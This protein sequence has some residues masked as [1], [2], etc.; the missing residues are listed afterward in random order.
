MLLSTLSEKGARDWL[1]KQQKAELVDRLTAMIHDKLPD[2]RNIRHE[3]FLIISLALVYKYVQPLSARWDELIEKALAIPNIADRVVAIGYVAV[4]LPGKQAGRRKELLTKAENLLEKLPSE[5]DR[6]QRYKWLARL[7][8]KD[9]PLF[10]R[11]FIGAVLRCSFALRDEELAAEGQREAIE[12]AHRID[13]D[14]ADQLA[15]SLDDDPARRRA[16]REIRGQLELLKTK[17]ALAE[18]EPLNLGDA[19]IRGRIPRAAWMNLAALNSKRLEPQRLEQFCDYLEY[20]ASV[21]L[22]VS[23]PVFAWTIESAARRYATTEQAREICVPV[24][25]AALMAS[26]FVQRMMVQIDD[27]IGAR[28]MTASDGGTDAI[29]IGDGEQEFARGLIADWIR[30]HVSDYIKICDPYFVPESLWVLKIVKREKPTARVSILLGRKHLDSATAG[31]V[32]PFQSAWRAISDA[33]PPETSLVIAGVGPT[34]KAPIHERWLVSESGGL[35]IGTS[36]QDIGGARISEIST[37]SAADAAVREQELDQYLYFEKR[38]QGG[39]RISY[40][41]FSLG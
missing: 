8:L 22:N 17:K 18:V 40:I 31:S 39:E 32:E 35:R 27:R 30:V 14:Y 11:R 37:L 41:G 21:Q 24:A 23:Y 20:A 33:D 4:S 28:R 15:R 38:V 36:I 19:E 7:T 16:R 1:N 3:G 25:E 10:A 26:S 12:L 13:P 34:G 6:V 2:V 9:E 29:L 5:I